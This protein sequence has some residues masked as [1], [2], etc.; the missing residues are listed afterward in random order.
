[1]GA[2]FGKPV[3]VT[4]RPFIRGNH[5]DP[6][7]C[8]KHPDYIGDYGYDTAHDLFY[9]GGAFSIDWKMRRTRMKL[10]PKEGP[11]WWDDEEVSPKELGNALRLYTKSKPKIMVSHE[12][13]SV[14]AHELLN[15][16]LLHGAA[17]TEKIESAN[18]RTART[19]QKM[20]E[21]H[22]PELWCFG[23]YHLD[24]EMQMGATKF[25]CVGECHGW[26]PYR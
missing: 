4:G 9:L 14:V 25:V 24:R 22:Q 16:M 18:S 1:M 12:C 17:S 10:F 6:A 23:H 15:T 20:F 26:M 7:V 19:L 21:A 11:I 2:G 13:P 8:R 5:D 3:P